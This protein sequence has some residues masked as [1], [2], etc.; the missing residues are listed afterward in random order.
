MPTFANRVAPF[1]TTIFSE[2]NNL[3]AEHGAVNLGQGRPDFDGPPDLINAAVKAL[4]G[5]QQYN[6]YPPGIGA[7]DFRQAVANHAAKFYGMEID[8]NR[9]VVATPG[10]TE[11]VFA[12]IMGLVDPGDEVIVIEPYFDSYVPN[13]LMAGAKP[14]FVPLH[15][16]EWTLDPDE[17]RRAFTPRTK[18]LLW[19]SPQN[20][21]GRVFTRA[22][23]Q[24]VA[25]LCI[26]H[27]VIVISDEVYEHL[28]FGTAQH[29]PIASLPGMFERTVTVSS[30]GK[31]YSVTG[32]KL[33]WVY[34]APELVTGVMRA[35]QFIAFA[36]HH[37]SQIA[38]AFAMGLPGTY[39]E[40][41]QSMYTAKR[42]IL[43]VGLN[44]AGLK[45]K[46]PEGTYFVM[47]DFSDVFD[48]ND[49][50]FTAHLIKNIGVA[51]IPPSPFYCEEHRHIASKQA[52]FAFCKGDDTLRQASERLA[53]LRR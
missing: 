10:A 23:M 18:A 27:D 9:G 37:P 39:Y 1:G 7:P 19:N 48:G 14:V 35:H 46:Q 24:V 2:I 31:S 17:L 51:C 42:D 21:T 3:A 28:V 50:E 40:D 26:E 11:A 33:G 52:R 34:G 25:D 30:L 49:V 5:G 32:W 45:A 4:Q 20:P 36:V 15:P 8:P 44:A 13:I 29:V 22:E 6:Q 43:M 47:A 38:G 12:S 16:P 41:L 53:K